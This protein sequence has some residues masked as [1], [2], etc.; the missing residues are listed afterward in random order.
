[1]LG[2][3]G[4]GEFNGHPRDDFVDEWSDE[5]FEDVMLGGESLIDGSLGD[6]RQLR[7]FLCCGA[8]VP[9]VGEK[10]QAGLQHGFLLCGEV[11][12]VQG[13]HEHV[14][15]RT[16]VVHQFPLRSI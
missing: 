16:A 11:G 15:D 4:V 5:G 6:V 10:G 13:L 9:F 2:M 12:G 8:V 3:H 1:M 14:L 7:D